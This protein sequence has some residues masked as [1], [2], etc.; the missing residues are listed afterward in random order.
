MHYSWPHSKV[1][2]DVSQ[3]P[4]SFPV[5]EQTRLHLHLNWRE[6]AGNQDKV[7]IVGLCFLK[8]LKF[9]AVG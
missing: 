3:A 9:K 7:F 5:D 2:I 8:M 1:S 4:T 6:V